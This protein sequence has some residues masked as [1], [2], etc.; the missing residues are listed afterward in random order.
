MAD[1]KKVPSTPA[2]RSD[3]HSLADRMYKLYPSN[4]RSV[5]RFEPKTGKVRTD[6]RGPTVQ[7]FVEH[8][9][10]R[11]GV[12]CVPITDKNYCSWAAVDIDNHGQDEDVPIAPIDRRLR[13]LR[14]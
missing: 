2:S 11:T 3:V 10:A 6:Y 14:A 13:E 4:Q 5:G 7:D 9:E 8:L 12:G 1:R